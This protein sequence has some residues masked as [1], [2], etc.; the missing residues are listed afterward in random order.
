MHA[1]LMVMHALTGH[2]K[3]TPNLFQAFKAIR[4]QTRSYIRLEERLLLE[5]CFHRPVTFVEETY[6]LRSI[7]K[8]TKQNKTKQDILAATISVA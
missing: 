2:T 3:T 5:I 6:Q 7:F 8:K 4:E 1:Q